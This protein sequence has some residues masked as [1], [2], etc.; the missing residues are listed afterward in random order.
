MREHEMYRYEMINQLI[1]THGYK[2]YLEIGTHHGTCHSRVVCD[3][4]VSVDP[5]KNYDQLT[6]VLTSDE[7]FAKY[8]DKFDIIFIDG[9]HLEHQS[10]LDIE[11][12]LKVLNPGGTI[13]AHDC[14]P[15]EEAHI[16]V[17]H[18]GTVFRSIIDFRYNNPNVEVCVVNSDC[19]CAIIQPRAQVLYNKVPIELAKTFFYYNENKQDLMN[20]I[21]VDEFKKRLENGLL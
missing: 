1:N 17:C 14:L 12:A 8:H 9:L 19:G 18:N 13:I 7:Y 16:R 21:S 6:H 15:E 4:K 11:N 5:D 10:T 2:T 3:Y 20:I